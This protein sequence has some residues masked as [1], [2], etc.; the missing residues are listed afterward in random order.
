MLTILFCFFM[1]AVF[2]KLTIFAIRTAWG[3][4]KVI[5]WLVF[6]PLMLAAL[7]F[8]GLVYIALPLLFIGGLIAFLESRT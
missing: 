6:A 5:L 7:F 3:I 2:G 4:T 8:L 1:F